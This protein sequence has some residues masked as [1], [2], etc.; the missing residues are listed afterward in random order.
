[1][2]PWADS[3]EWVQEKFKEQE[4]EPPK[5]I[6][7]ILDKSGFQRVGIESSATFGSDAEKATLFAEEMSEKG[8]RVMLVTPTEKG[9]LAWTVENGLFHEI[10]RR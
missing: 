10:R 1:M 4:K 6:T 9:I 2:S 3:E 5:E 8:Y 7:V